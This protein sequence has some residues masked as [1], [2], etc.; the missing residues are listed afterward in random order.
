MPVIDQS[1]PGEKQDELDDRSGAN[2][3]SLQLIIGSEEKAWM[4]RDCSDGKAIRGLLDLLFWRQVLLNRFAL[5][6]R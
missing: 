1:E 6:T 3:D 2:G 4:C 5:V